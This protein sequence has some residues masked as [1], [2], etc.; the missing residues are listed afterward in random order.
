MKIA[1]VGCGAMGSVYAAL[2]ADAGHE[3][4]AIDSW[5]GHVEAM[6]TKGLHLEGASGE[7][8][9]RLHATTDPAEA[10][11]C[12]LVI[13][14][15][16]AM[17][18]EQAAIASKPL[19]SNDTLVLSIQ[20]GLGGPDTTARVLGRDKVMVGVVGGFGASMRGPGHAHHNGWELVR[21]GEFS[22]PVTPRLETVA[23]V[24]RSGGFRVKCFDDIDQ[25]V[26]EKLI[27]NVCFSGTCTVT[28]L[29]IEEVM[30][31]ADTWQVASG[32]AVEAYNVAK[33]RKINVDIDDPVEYVRNFGSKIPKARP[34]MLLDHLAGRMSEIEAING[35]I[36]PAA[37]AV[38]TAAP[39]NT[40]ISALV[41]NKERQMGVRD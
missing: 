21:L 6:R 41:R 3:I 33:A 11:P 32:C 31:D 39:F 10:G 38:G 19:V 37:A 18:V 20:N 13:I 8:T 9:V 36:P 7:R 12:E 40:V 2:L 23:E 17:H 27:C 26:W 14:A 30:N 4:W 22:G 24:W 35:A 29:T 25:L 16:K 34:S 1:I 28:G 5:K 15:T